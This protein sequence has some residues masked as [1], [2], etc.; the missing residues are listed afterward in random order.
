MDTSLNRTIFVLCLRLVLAI[1]PRAHG[2]GAYGT[3]QCHYVKNACTLKLIGRLLFLSKTPKLLSPPHFKTWLKIEPRTVAISGNKRN[4]VSLIW[5][6]PKQETSVWK[7]VQLIIILEEVFEYLGKLSADV[8]R[9]IVW[10]NCHFLGPY[11]TYIFVFLEP[12]QIFVLRMDILF[13]MN[14]YF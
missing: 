14:Q 5:Q 12:L 1:C 4:G 10:Q 6:P 13:F 11:R 7:S 2:N 9:E 8:F 3:F